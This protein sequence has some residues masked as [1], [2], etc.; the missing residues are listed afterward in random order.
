[1]IDAF[2]INTR[3]E[4]QLPLRYIP[5]VIDRM[6]AVRTG[7]GRHRWYSAPDDMR[8]AIPARQTFLHQ[9]SAQPGSYLW[10]LSFHALDGTAN[11]FLLQIW[12][13][14]QQHPI[15]G[16]PVLAS[17]FVTLESA[18]FRPFLLAEPELLENGLVNV[19][20][21]NTAAAD[22]RCQLLLWITE[23]GGE[24]AA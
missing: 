8:I 15:A 21:H 16:S 14:E 20:I 9:V 24:R 17:H 23:P 1:M 12:D 2:T 7:P 18:R 22:Q 10:G 4:D 5:R 3:L 6:G 19:E 11:Q 13:G